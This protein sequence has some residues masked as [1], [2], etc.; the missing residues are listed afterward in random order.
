L[1][2]LG[3]A[4]LGVARLALNALDGSVA[5]RTQTATPSGAVANE[6][7][8]RLADWALLVPLAAFVSPSLVLTAVLAAL[9]VSLCGVLAQ[10]L[11]G[12]RATRG[13]MG[14]ADRIAVL[15]T[16]SVI[17]AV[18]SAPIVFVIALATV[19]FGSLVTIV[20][21]LKGLLAYLAD[22]G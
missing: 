3:V 5:R 13:P 19:I 1:L 20:L 14:K 8:D 4:P 10:A 7:C 22:A 16:A 21:R 15:S 18:T 2:W 17:G 12:T 11:T 9:S 6:V